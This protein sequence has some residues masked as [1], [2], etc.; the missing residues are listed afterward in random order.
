MILFFLRYI[1]ETS[2]D[3]PLIQKNA[4]MD[5]GKMGAT[6]LCSLYPFLSKKTGKKN[7]QHLLS[8]LL[9]KLLRENHGRRMKRIRI[10]CIWIKSQI[11]NYCY[12]GRPHG[13]VVK[14]ACSTAP[15]GFRWFRS[16][17]W[18]WHH[19][20]GHVEAASHM[21]QLEGPTTK[22]TQLCTR[23]FWG[24]KGKIKSL[25]RKLAEL[26]TSKGEFYYM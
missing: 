5:E 2:L 9:G 16:W 26:Y 6:E 24:E 10:N 4:S 18:T 8:F 21:P 12:G 14:F 3:L 7:L 19:S 13:R 20:S 11:K 15:P 25:K 1:T 22:N 23:G 17:V